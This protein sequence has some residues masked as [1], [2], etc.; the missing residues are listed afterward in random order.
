MYV[1]V[2]YVRLV[3]VVPKNNKGYYNLYKTLQ[4][5]FNM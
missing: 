5:L 3:K 1:N 4:N 2:L